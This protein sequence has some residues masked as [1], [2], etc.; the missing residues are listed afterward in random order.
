[1]SAIPSIA[2]GLTDSPEKAAA[3]AIAYVMIQMLEN[4]LL[5]PLLM[6]EGVDLPPVLTIL[7][8]AVMAFVFGFIGLFVAVPILVLTTVFVRML[9]VEDELEAQ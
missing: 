2:V 7:T 9:Y 6:K 1:L 8:Q 3:V 5:I 4:H